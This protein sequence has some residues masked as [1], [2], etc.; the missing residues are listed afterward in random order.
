M[1]IMADFTHIIAKRQGDQWSAWFED[2]P[3]ILSDGD[4][5][6]DAIY[7]LME[8]HELPD[9]IMVQVVTVDEGTDEEPLEIRVTGDEC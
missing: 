4:I 5:V 1:G 2:A 3:H 6:T 9:L 7:G 8:L